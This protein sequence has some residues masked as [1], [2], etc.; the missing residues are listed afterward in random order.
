[1]YH[2]ITPGIRSHKAIANSAAVDCHRGRI[3]SNCKT[4]RVFYG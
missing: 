4:L 3:L 1:M 2:T